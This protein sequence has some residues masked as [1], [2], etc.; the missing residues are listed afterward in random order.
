MI[1]LTERTKYT[2]KV[3]PHIYIYILY[4]IYMDIDGY[5]GKLG[6]GNV[7]QLA[8]KHP[9]FQITTDP[10][11]VDHQIMGIMMNHETQKGLV[12]SKPWEFPC[13]GDIMILKKYV[14]MIPNLV[15]VNNWLL[16]SGYLTK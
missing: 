9:I 13:C 5:N 12:F 15:N 7:L 6:S 4:Y 14:E 3:P 8:M 1:V 16:P 2:P 10:W 11:K